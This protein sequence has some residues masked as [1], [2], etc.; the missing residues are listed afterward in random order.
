MKTQALACALLVAL[1]G[2]SGAAQVTR[3]IPYDHIH[4]AVPDPDKAY[5]CV[6]HE[7]RWAAG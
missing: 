6:R 4:L 7:S 1:F 5:E 2:I 3:T